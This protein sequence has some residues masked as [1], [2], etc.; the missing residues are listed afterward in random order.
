MFTLSNILLT[1]LLLFI[2]ISYFIGFF[3]ILEAGPIIPWWFFENA[4][5]IRKIL[6]WY[7]AICELLFVFSIIIPIFIFSLKITQE[8]TKPESQPIIEK[9]N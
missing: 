9:T 7:F 1:I 5:I 8:I 2:F 3:M 4:S 6:Y